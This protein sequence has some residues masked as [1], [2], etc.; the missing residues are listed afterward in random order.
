MH[1]GRNT[2]SEARCRSR[3]T[4]HPFNQHGQFELFSKPATTVDW[5]DEQLDGVLSS[6]AQIY[7]QMAKVLKV[8]QSSPLTRSVQKVRRLTQSVTR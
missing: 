7:E 2:R 4:Q 6:Q 8:L 5:Y 1:H 3:V